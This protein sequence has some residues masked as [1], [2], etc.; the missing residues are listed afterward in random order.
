MQAL[1]MT[2]ACA[3]LLALLAPAAPA[4]GWPARPVKLVVPFP[5]GSAADQVARLAGAEPQA[6]LGEPFVVENKPGAQGAIAA[7]E[8]AKAAAD[9]DTLRLTTHTPHAAN[10]RA[11]A[12]PE[13]KEKFAAVGTD[14]APL[15]P[16]ELGRFIQ[17]EIEH[18]AKLVKLA[19]IQPE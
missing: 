9:G 5:A 6:A 16:A 1:V 17:S 10:M 3:A 14:V 2:A 15:G 18:W 13:V 11:L 7:A 12:R 8:V 19:G 4:Q